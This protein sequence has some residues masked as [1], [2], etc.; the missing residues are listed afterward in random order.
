MITEWAVLKRQQVADYKLFTLHKKQA[1][2]PR[3]GEIREVLALQFPDWVLTLALTPEKEV[4]MVRQ[5]RHGTEQVCL[6][7]PGGLVDPG[8]L[9]PESS[10]QRELL[11]E[12]GFTVANIRLIGEC[13]PQP[14][15]LSNR[16][17]FYLAEDA[18]KTQRQNL[19]AG[20]DIDILTIPL[21]DIRAKIENK[22]IDHGMVLQAFFF[23]WLHRGP[24][25][26]LLK[27]HV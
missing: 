19:D 20:E 4:V 1:R 5:Y 10:A 18:V 24:E 14:A 23:L 26:D 27:A 21:K 6:E 11:E 2:S 25:T 15:I 22:E 12:T 3:T 9:S 7:L 16:C 17:F 13:Y 8:D